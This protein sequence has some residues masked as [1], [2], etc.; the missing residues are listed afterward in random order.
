MQPDQMILKWDSNE[1]QLLDSDISDGFNH[2][3]KRV[4]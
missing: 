2:H 1:L 3:F 4:K